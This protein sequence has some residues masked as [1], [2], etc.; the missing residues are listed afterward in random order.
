MQQAL[1]P[2]PG[3]ARAEIV[4]AEFFDQFDATV[5]EPHAAFDAGFGRE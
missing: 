4:A 1:K 3:A 5:N 2:A